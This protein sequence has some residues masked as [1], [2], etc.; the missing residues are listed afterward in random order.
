MSANTGFVV[1]ADEKLPTRRQACDG[2]CPYTGGTHLRAADKQYL[3]V[4]IL[5]CFLLQLTPP[6]LPPMVKTKDR[7]QTNHLL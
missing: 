4:Q 3:S 5:S 1:L 7:I 2:I 6:F